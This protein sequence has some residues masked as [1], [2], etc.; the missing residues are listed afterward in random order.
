MKLILAGEKRSRIDSGKLP[1]LS[2]I[3][4][5]PDFTYSRLMQRYRHPCFNILE[6]LEIMTGKV[7]RV[8]RIFGVKEIYFLAG[9]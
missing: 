7:S 2:K 5:E 4:E 3:F 8:K 9:I 6:C 1:V